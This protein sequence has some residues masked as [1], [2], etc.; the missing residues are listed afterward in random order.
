MRYLALLYGN[1]SLA[2]APDT[3]E[4]EAE[5]AAYAK[6]SED[7]GAAIVAGEA[8][9]PSSTAFTVRSGDG[10][11]LV[12][13]GPFAESTEVVGGMYVLEADGMD[14]AVDLARQI[15]AALYGAVELR[16]LVEW[17]DQ[18]TDDET[19]PPGSRYFA[20]ILGAPT[21]ADIPGTAAWD[22]GAAAHGEFAKHAGDAV[23][24]GGALHPASTA[25]TV[26]VRDGEVLVTDGPFTEAA[27][28][29]GGV[30]VLQSTDH[31][32]IVDLA[33]KIPTNPGG[34]VEV[35][36]VVDFG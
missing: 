11:P 25:T 31:D 12:T 23:R 19:P 33:G 14:R 17:Y 8:L 36:R 9:M 32:T 24:A 29:V 30:Y 16:P 26:R 15:P 1:E 4:W 7:E 20:L 18:R 34:A 6:F 35:W 27:E 22:E 3:P 10:A 28:V 5:M 2:A 21:E 13:Q